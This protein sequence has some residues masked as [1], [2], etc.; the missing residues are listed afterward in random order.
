M[1]AMNKKN[2]FT[3]EQNVAIVSVKHRHNTQYS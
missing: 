2:A 1:F 3:F